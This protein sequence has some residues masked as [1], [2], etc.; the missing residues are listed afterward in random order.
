LTTPE[1]KG[2]GNKNDAHMVNTNNKSCETE[3]QNNANK[4]NDKP[5]SKSIHQKVVKDPREDLRG[6]KIDKS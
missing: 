6:V 1:H 4:L 3:F 5:K 2:S